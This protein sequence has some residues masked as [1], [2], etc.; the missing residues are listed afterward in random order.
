M[1]IYIDSDYKCHI[2]NDGTMTAV[3]TD[4]FDGKCKDFIEGH[5]LYPAGTLNEGETIFPWKDYTLLQAAQ[6]GY[7]NCLADAQ[8][9]YAQGVNSI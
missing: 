8:S 6:S 4:F 7:E 9:A 5:K 2:T 1:I 3:K